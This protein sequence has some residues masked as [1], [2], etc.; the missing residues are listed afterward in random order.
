MKNSKNNKLAAHIANFK[1]NNIKAIAIKRNKQN[2]VEEVVL[3]NGKKKVCLE[4]WENESGKYRSHS[5]VPFNAAGKRSSKE[6]SKKYRTLTLAVSAIGE[7]F[8]KKL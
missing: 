6:R 7:F 2:E 8:G 1:T 5:L 3:Q 4:F